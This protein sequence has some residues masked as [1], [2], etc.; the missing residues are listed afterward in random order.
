MMKRNTF[1]LPNRLVCDDRLS[2]SARKVGAILYAHRNAFGFCTKTLDALAG[3]SGCCAAT[4]RKATE[5]LT[6]A[7]YISVSR[8]YRYLPRKRRTVYGRKTYQVNLGFQGGYTLIPRDFLDW[9]QRQEELTPAAFV[10]CLYLF[11][12]AGNTRR[13]FPSI[14]RIGR[15]VGVARSTVCRALLQIKLL[16]GFLIQF[17]RKRDGSFAA[18]SYHIAAILVPG[19]EAAGALGTIPQR[20]ATAEKPRRTWDALHA[21]IV[22]AATSLCNLFRGHGVVPFLANNC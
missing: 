18:S 17:C 19:Q 2:P 15:L 12:A 16:S 1:K 10:V 13:A 3:L 14:S 4:V 11:V 7:G 5:E 21:L 6:A 9:Q 8:T 22:K 20:D